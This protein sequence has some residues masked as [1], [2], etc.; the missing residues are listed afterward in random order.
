VFD[1]IGLRLSAAVQHNAGCVLNLGISVDS[2]VDA[3]DHPTSKMLVVSCPVYNFLE[4][5]GIVLDDTLKIESVPH[6]LLYKYPNL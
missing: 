2:R 3:P 5:I 4:L 1:E 6:N